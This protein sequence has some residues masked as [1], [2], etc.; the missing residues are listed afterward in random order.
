MDAMSY[1]KAFEEL[2]QNNQYGLGSGLSRYTV[3]NLVTP[4]LTGLRNGEAMRAAYDVGIRQVVSDAS[5]ACQT[6]P[7]PNTGYYNAL[8]P[9]LLQV[10]R[11]PTDLYFN[12][13]LP[14]EWVAEYEMLHSVS[15]VTY[16][17]II[18][19]ESTAQLRYLLRGASNPWMFHQANLRDVGGGQSLITAFLDA[20][21]NKYA[22]RATFPVVSPTMD[23]LARTMKARM[24]FDAAGIS[25]TIE[26]GGK[27]TVKVEKAATVPVTGLCTPAAEAY[28]GQQISYLPL[29]AGQSI[30]L[31]LA[32]CNPDFVAV[33]GTGGTGGDAGTGDAGGDGGTGGAGGDGMMPPGPTVGGNCPPPTGTGG[34]GGEGGGGTGGAAG[35]GGGGGDTTMGSLSTD[36]GT[37]PGVYGEGGSG[38][39][40][41]LSGGAHDRAGGAALIMLVLALA[42]PAAT[43]RGSGELRDAAELLGQ[44]HS[45]ETPHLGEQRVRLLARDEP[46]LQRRRVAAGLLIRRAIP[47]AFVGVQIVR[48]GDVAVK[49]ASQAGRHPLGGPGQKQETAD[50]LVHL[51]LQLQLELRDRPVPGG[52]AAR[53]RR[54]G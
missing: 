48:V 46:V 37:D 4:S 36:A 45:V 51:R 15:G 47:L 52:G 50:E 38:C 31:S 28:A 17:Q 20:V 22:A 42:V 14:A 29:A 2:S 54:S 11:F 12:V 44:V 21:L 1:A 34:S 8:A 6:N 43:P 3:E 35:A 26:P 30:T 5:A 16:E 49:S 23:E 40:C 53:R 32:D 39:G 27:L 33:G 25:A 18:E 13:S 19:T 7:T 41:L 10:P 9:G 24:A